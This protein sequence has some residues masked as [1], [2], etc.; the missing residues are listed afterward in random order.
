MARDIMQVVHLIHVLDGT[1]PGNWTREQKLDHL[2]MVRENRDITPDEAI[3]L[4]VYYT[5]QW[6][7]EDLVK[8]QNER[9][10]KS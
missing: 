5:S 9:M 7:A 10:K 6:Q 3:D 8:E 2:K 1:A 4:A